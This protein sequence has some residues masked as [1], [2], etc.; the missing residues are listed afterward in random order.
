MLL[1][2]MEIALRLVI[3]YSTYHAFSRTRFR[4]HAMDANTAVQT[5]LNMRLMAL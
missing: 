2:R 1:H 5:R 3:D 4:A